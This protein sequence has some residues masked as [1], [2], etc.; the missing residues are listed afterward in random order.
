MGWA[1]MATRRGGHQARRPWHRTHVQQ[2]MF[3]AYQTVPTIFQDLVRVTSSNKYEE[4]YAPL[5]NS[6]LP[7]E[8]LPGEAFPDSRI[9]GLDVHVRNRKFG[10][11]LAFQREIR[12]KNREVSHVL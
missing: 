12:D 9:I 8:V 4:L 6:E 5:Y 11:L 10:R 3:D 2:F 1:A 7:V